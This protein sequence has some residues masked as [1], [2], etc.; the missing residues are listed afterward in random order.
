[1]PKVVKISQLSVHLAQ[2]PKVG[3]APRPVQ[4]KV[5]VSCPAQRSHK[6]TKLHQTWPS[7]R[8]KVPMHAKVLGFFQF[9]LAAENERF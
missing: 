8:A 6:C 1:M 9:A 5:A 2:Q 7:G 3:A 4:S